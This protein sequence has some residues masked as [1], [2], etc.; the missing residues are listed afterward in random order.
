VPGATDLAA[1]PRKGVRTLNLA[2]VTARG[3][4]CTPSWGG[5]TR[6]D[7]P[8]VAQ[9]IKAFRNAG[10][11][12]RVSFGGAGGVELA[13]ACPTSAAL[14]TA[15]AHVLDALG[16]RL[17]DLDIEGAT[18]QDAAAVRR[19]NEAL[20]RLEADAE[21]RGRAVEISYTLPAEST[22]LTPPAQGLLR[23]AR[24]VGLAPAVVDVLAMNYADVPADLV[25]AGAGAVDAA[26]S[27][28]VSVWGQGAPRIA[29]T[30]MIG[31][32]DIRSQVLSASDAERF[33]A[34]ARQRAVAWL[35]YWSLGRDRPCPGGPSVL[36]PS[37]SGML[38]PPR[39]F[40]DALTR[41]AGAAP[42]G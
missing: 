31:V 7:D 5:T 4:E 27:F 30:V 10:G 33:A 40:L 16:A 42:R 37:C 18:L 17:V 41:S 14:A 11:E 13:S 24:T 12:V 34:A 2:F 25:T 1:L 22:G 9:L 39:A 6:I 19:R 15:Y 38:D 23:D 29:A 35:G 28:V 8:V 20:R 3:G 32:N 26:R 36:S 21:K